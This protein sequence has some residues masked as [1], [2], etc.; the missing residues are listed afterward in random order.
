M[1]SGEDV[2]IAELAALVAS[3]TGYT[4]ALEW[5]TSK[6]DGTMSKRLDVSR[7]RAAGWAPT[8]ELHRGIAE[9]VAWY[10][11]NVLPHGAG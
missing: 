4:G 6:P 5:D 7:L 8:V 1:G 10:R 3:A 9:T 11:S 2:S